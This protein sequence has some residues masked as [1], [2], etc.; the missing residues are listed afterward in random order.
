[1]KLKDKTAVVTG[2]SRGIGRS[3]AERFAKEGALVVIHYGSNAKAVRPVLLGAGEPAQDE[4]GARRADRPGQRQHDH[5]VRD[6][7]FRDQR[8]TERCD[9]GDPQELHFRIR[10]RR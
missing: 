9:G 7:R 6:N 1:M 4:I 5:R 8:P 3:I 10:W 2:S